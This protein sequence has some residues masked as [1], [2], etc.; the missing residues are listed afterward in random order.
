MRRLVARLAAIL[1]LIIGFLWAIL[2]LDA[3][4]FALAVVVGLGILFGRD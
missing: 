1:L 4:I 2:S 3:T